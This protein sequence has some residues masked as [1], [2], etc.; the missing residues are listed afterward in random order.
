MDET[1][2]E[3]RLTLRLTGSYPRFV[4][5]TLFRTTVS[6]FPRAPS[7]HFLVQYTQIIQDMLPIHLDQTFELYQR[8]PK[9][10]QRAT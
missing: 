10:V 1:Y 9:N 2:L 3:E 4:S 5:Q 7:S 8:T 6:L